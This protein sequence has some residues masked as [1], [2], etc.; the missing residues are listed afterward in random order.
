MFLTNERA[1]VVD[2]FDGVLFGQKEWSTAT[3]DNVGDSYTMQHHAKSKKQDTKGH[4]WYNS[5]Y[6]KHLE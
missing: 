4:G 1:D 5:A 6:M 3:C 2:P